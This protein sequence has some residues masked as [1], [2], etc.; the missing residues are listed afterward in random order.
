MNTIGYGLGLM[1]NRAQN[2]TIRPRAFEAMLEAGTVDC[3]DVK[4]VED[5]FQVLITAGGETKPLGLARGTKV[6]TFKHLK[7]ASAWLSR[8]GV[9]RALEGPTRA[10][11]DPLVR[12]LAKLRDEIY[13]GTAVTYPDVPGECLREAEEIIAQIEARRR[14][15]NEHELLKEVVEEAARR[16]RR[17]RA[18]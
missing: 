9:E 5:G 12:R 13:D 3:I 8:R 15:S 18:A 16:N 7:T 11:K 14:K 2:L 6:R 4:P 10:D 1:P 17:A